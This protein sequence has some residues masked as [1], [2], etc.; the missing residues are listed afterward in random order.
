MTHAGR[1]SPYQQAQLF[2]GGLLDHIRVDVEMHDPQD[3]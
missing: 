2:A 1:L 3:L